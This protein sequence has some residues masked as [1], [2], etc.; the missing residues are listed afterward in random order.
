MSPEAAI[1][2]HQVHL[3]E[4]KPSAQAVWRGPPEDLTSLTASSL[5]PD[6]W[7]LPVLPI[8]D[9]FHES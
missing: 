1:V 5:N 8:S 7:G 3:I 6:E 9:P 2:D 4:Y